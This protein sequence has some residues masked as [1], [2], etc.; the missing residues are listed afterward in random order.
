MKNKHTLHPGNGN[1]WP[2]CVLDALTSLAWEVSPTVFRLLRTLGPI[3]PPVE[4]HFAPSG[5]NSAL[6]ASG[7][8]RVL[9]ALIGICVLIPSTRVH[10][11][12]TFPAKRDTALSITETLRA[13]EIRP[14]SDYLGVLG[15]GNVSGGK[16][17]AGVRLMW[18]QSNLAHV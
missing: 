12:L 13:S 9:F 7:P 2:D 15:P 6:S 5:A 3:A 1:A 11:H 8:P 16:G 14:A 17:E 18:L 4:L 10:F